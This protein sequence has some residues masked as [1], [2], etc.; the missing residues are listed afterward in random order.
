MISRTNIKICQLPQI[1][2][3]K[4]SMKQNLKKTFYLIFSSHSILKWLLIAKKW[5]QGR[6]KLNKERKYL[7]LG[8]GFICSNIVRKQISS[9]LSK[10]WKWCTTEFSVIIIHTVIAAIKAGFLA[11]QHQ[12]GSCSSD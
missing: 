6:K 10:I 7:S 1:K 3:G 8:F 11:C 2:L 5:Q 9:N 4:F 12:N